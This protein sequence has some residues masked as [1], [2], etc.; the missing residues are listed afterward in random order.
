M[1]FVATGIFF[2]A[3][4][5]PMEVTVTY[6]GVVKNYSNS[7]FFVVTNPFPETLSFI[8]YVRFG[9]NQLVGHFIN[10]QWAQFLNVPAFSQ[11]NIYVGIAPTNP[12]RVVGQCSKIGPVSSI[13]RIRMNL[14]GHAFN[15]GWTKCAHWLSPL[16]QL[17]PVYG[18]LMLGNKPAPREPK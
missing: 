18:P 10:T 5:K 8:M 17:P 15:R 16:T 13:T 2:L 4:Q 9:T 12:W 3:K 11:T 6:G 7:V 14:A 1:V